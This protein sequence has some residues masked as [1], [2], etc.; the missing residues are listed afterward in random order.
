[1]TSVVNELSGVVVL[2]VI[3]LGGGALYYFNKDKDIE[4][5]PEVVQEETQKA[6]IKNVQ[7]TMNKLTLSS[8]AFEEGGLIPSKYTCDGENVNPELSISGVPEGTVSLALIMDDPD[9][10]KPAGHVWDHWVK[11]N[12]PPTV[13][14]IDE[15]SDPEGVSGITSRE[16]LTYGGPCPPDGEHRYFFKLYALDTKLSLR[17][18]ATKAEVERAMEGHILEETQLMGRYDRQ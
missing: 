4:Q 13:T 17:E 15:N 11:F 12:I 3:V 10:V 18:G 7:V 1:M 6:T 8:S 5:K 2:C 16:V 14:K 9:A